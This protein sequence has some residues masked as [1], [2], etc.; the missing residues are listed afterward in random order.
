MSLAPL[1][2]LYL[3]SGRG[4][5]KIPLQRRSGIF[6]E[7]RGCRELALVGGEVMR[8]QRAVRRMRDNEKRI[9]TLP[10]RGL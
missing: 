8:K 4:R 10:E 1:V 5:T 9:E 6:R 7:R 2:F 3:F